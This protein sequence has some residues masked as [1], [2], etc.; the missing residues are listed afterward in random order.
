MS[1]DINIFFFHLNKKSGSI[2]HANFS[3]HA[4]FIK[5]PLQKPGYFESLALVLQHS[6][7]FVEVN[8]HDKMYMQV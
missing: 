8:L 1:R 4:T 2:Y 5:N 3:H 7:I 6:C